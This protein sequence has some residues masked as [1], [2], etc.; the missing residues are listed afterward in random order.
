MSRINVTIDHIVVRGFEPGDRSALLEAL[1]TELR[2]V[3]TDPAAKATWAHPQR[4]ELLN[5]GRMPFSAGRSGSKDLG[6]R[7]ARAIGKGLK[8]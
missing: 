1:Q 8:P 5:L 6:S 7:I 4:T 2:H 3:L